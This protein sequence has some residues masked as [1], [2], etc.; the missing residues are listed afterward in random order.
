MAIKKFSL[1][2][3]IVPLVFFLH[4]CGNGAGP[5]FT[6]PGK[7]PGQPA[8]IKLF[9]ARYVAQTNGCIDFFAEVHDDDGEILANIPVTFT[10]LSE[11]FGVILDRCGGIEIHTPVNTDSWGRAK[12]TLMSTTPGFATILAQTTLGGQPRDRKTVLFSFCDTYECLVL[13]P[14]LRLDVDSVPGNGVYNETSDFIIFEP[15]P[16]PDNTVE[17]L[18]TV[19]NEYGVPIQDAGVCFGSDHTEAAYT[20]TENYTNVN[21]QAKGILQV[22]PQSIRDTETYVTA[23]AQYGSLAQDEDGNIYCSYVYAYNVVTL[24]LQP[25]VIAS[26]MVTADPSS[27]EPG[28]TS[29]ISA[30]VVLNTGDPAPD[31]TSVIFT[32]Y[33]ATTC[34]ACDDPACTDPC[35]YVDYFGQ[36]TAGIAP[37]TFTGPPSDQICRIIAKANGVCGSTTVIVAEPLSV[38][39]SSDD[40]C[41]STV[42]CTAGQNNTTLTISGG[43][44]PYTVT[45]SDNTVIADPGSLAGNTFTVNAT[46]GSIT[47]DT[48]VTLTI[49]D[50]SPTPQTVTAVVNVIN[51]FI[52]ISTTPANGATGVATDTPV[53]INWDDAVDCATVNTTNITINPNTPPAWALTSCG[54]VLNQATFTPTGQLGSTTYTV[55]IS[56]AVTDLTGLPMSVTYTFSYSTP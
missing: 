49:T 45:S 39:P 4:S 20:R 13:A 6:S 12:I 7:G 15:P 42:L 44:T 3:L 21:G 33:D 1:L 28:E 30:L 48:P 5:G 19:Y 46:D 34:T 36:T 29:D 27:I 22:I 53:V 2:F 41:E 23:W 24:F 40:I 37:A 32:S 31:G 55:V 18:A 8:Y 56:T 52:V 26:V 35:G 47:A 17:L 51:E 10:N 25:V 50:S 16:D 11:P 14:S 43:I 54:V 38:E 9:P